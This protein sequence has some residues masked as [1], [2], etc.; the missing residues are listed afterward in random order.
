[1][2]VI[3]HLQGSHWPPPMPPAAGSDLQLDSEPSMEEAGCRLTSLLPSF[4]WRKADSRGAPGYPTYWCSGGAKGIRSGAPGSGLSPAQPGSL[5]YNT[6]RYLTGKQGRQMGQ[7]LAGHFFFWLDIS[8]KRG[9]L[10]PPSHPLPSFPRRPRK[11]G[12]RKSESWETMESAEPAE[13]SGCPALGSARCCKGIVSWWSIFLWLSQH[14][15]PVGPPDARSGSAHT[16]EV[17]PL[18]SL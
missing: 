15:S 6:S 9:P 16:S 8:S 17:R 12:P 10:S 3:L 5:M 2:A 13:Q 1:M 4:G 11:S 7:E 18:S 14:L